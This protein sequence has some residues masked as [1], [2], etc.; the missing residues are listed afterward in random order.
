M[1]YNNPAHPLPRIPPP[2]THHHVS[3]AKNRVSFTG[4]PIKE[5]H[6]H[7]GEM[8]PD[9]HVYLGLFIRPPSP[10]IAPPSK[11]QILQKI[12]QRKDVHIR[13]LSGSTPHVFPDVA[14]GGDGFHIHVLEKDRELLS[15]RQCQ[16]VTEG[17]SNPS[18]LIL[19]NCLLTSPLCSLP[20]GRKRSPRC[21]CNWRGTP[22]RA[23]ASLT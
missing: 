7:D 17:K 15:D 18:A 14:M 4:K 13:V 19:P 23:P 21:R 16:V 20:R 10:Q 1:T 3:F 5:Y 12:T 22:C 2:G 11:G 8:L 6:F 9:D